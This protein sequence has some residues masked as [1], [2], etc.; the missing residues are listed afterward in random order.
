L[1]G[2]QWV[3]DTGLVRLPALTMFLLAG[4]SRVTAAGIAGLRARGVWVVQR[5]RPDI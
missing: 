3:T 5:P 2:N 1:G 4:N